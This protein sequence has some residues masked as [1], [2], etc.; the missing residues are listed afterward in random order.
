[1]LEIQGSNEIAIVDP[2]VVVL[3]IGLLVV[4]F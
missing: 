2:I 4:Y 3:G 1:M